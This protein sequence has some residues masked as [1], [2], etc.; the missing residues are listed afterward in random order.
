MNHIKSL[1]ITFAL[2]LPLLASAAGTVE[3]KAQYHLF[4]PVPKEKM[5]DFVTDR[6]DRT[7]SPISVDAGHFQIETDLVVMTSNTET[8]GGQEVKTTGTSWMLS[9]VKFGLTRDIDF[10]VV[11]APVNSVKAEVN[12]TEVAN[13]SGFGDTTLRLKVNLM[14]NDEGDFALGVM[15][16]VTLPTNSDGLGHKK[17]EG[18]FWVPFG[19]SLAD[20]WGLGGMFQYNRAKNESDDDFHNEYVTSLTVGHPIVGELSGY[21]EFWN[22]FSTETDSKW[23]ATVDFGLTYMLI[24]DVQ[25]DAGVNIGVTEATD[26]L[27]PFIGFSARI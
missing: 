19:Y 14:G 27:N 3:E 17:Y 23:Q 15:P 8:A 10:Q 7:E 22:Q 12:G 5:R 2:A 18:G 9:N 25:L 26:D 1:I 4:N 21:G 13:T 16:F 24:P 6:P 11:I 20:E